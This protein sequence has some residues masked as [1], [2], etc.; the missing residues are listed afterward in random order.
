LPLLPELILILVDHPNQYHITIQQQ[1]VP[2]NQNVALHYSLT[3]TKTLQFQHKDKRTIHKMPKKPT[4]TRLV[5]TKYKKL[6]MMQNMW[7]HFISI[8]WQKEF[9]CP[10]CPP[11]SLI[12]P[13]PPPSLEHSD[14]SVGS[15]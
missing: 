2:S 1:F 14:L 12:V 4:K 13:H 8:H 15:G 11:P 5:H 9:K 10:K 7:C 6:W 3:C